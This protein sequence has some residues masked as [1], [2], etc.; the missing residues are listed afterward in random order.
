MPDSYEIDGR[1]GYRPDCAWW[2]F[3]RVSKLA[4]FRW[5]EMTRDI[6]KIW[7]D[8]ED[9]IFQ[10]QQKIEVQALLLFKKDPQ[11]ARLFL[12]DY[13]VKAANQAVEAY[14]KLGNDLWSK[15]NNLF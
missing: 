6:E 2:S 4:L 15:Y 13:C 12:T 9:K 10:D 14:W 8:I 5:Q 11:K 7:K 1:W 3:R